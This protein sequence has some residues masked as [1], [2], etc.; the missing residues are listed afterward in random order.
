[1]S[2]AQAGPHTGRATR[3]SDGVR[4][5]V[6]PAVQAAGFDLEELAVTQ[7]GRRRLVRVVIDSDDGLD[8][9]QVAVV[10][11]QLSDLL[12]SCD[13]FS[14]PFVLEVTSPGVD[15]PLTQP[16]HWRRAVGRL[17]RVNIADEQVTARV[18]D[19]D[20]DGVQL[21]IGDSTRYVQWAL[22]S[23][24]KVQVEFSR[25]DSTDLDT[26]EHDETVEGH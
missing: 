14:E 19:S 9:D 1:M 20:D 16:K 22:L 12:D 11:R 17:V 23:S 13:Q 25:V 15:R 21:T 18:G 26:F 5:V 6:A 3:A 7:V 8:L 2:P 10:S 4:D 24:A